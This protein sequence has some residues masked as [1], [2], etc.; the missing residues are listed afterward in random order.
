MTKTNTYDNFK[1]I[2]ISF[3]RIYFKLILANSKINYFDKQRTMLENSILVKF[4]N[5]HS[6]LSF[7]VCNNFE[8]EAT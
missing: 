4:N 6:A 2:K 3:S 1:N 7:S 8:I 5:Y